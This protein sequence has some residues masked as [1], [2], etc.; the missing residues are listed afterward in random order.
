MKNIITIIL[1]LTFTSAWSQNVRVI[2]EIVAVIGEN[3]VMRSELEAEYAQA[4]KDMS[5][6]E[7]DLKC[8]ILNQLVIQKLYLH[9]GDVDSVYATEDRV[10]AEVDR[11]IKYYA[12]Q[13]GG[14]ARLEEYLGKSVSEYKDQMRPKIGQ[15]MVTQQVKQSLISSV[16]ASPTDVRKF[17]ND[18]PKDSLPEFGIEVE[19]ALIAMKPTSSDYAKEYALEKITKIRKDISSGIY[20]FDFAAKSSSDDK[21]TSI[22]GGDLGYFSRGQ[23]VGAFERAAFKLEKDS[24]SEVIETEYGYHIIQLLDRKGDKVNARHILIK[25]LIVNSDLVRLKGELTVLQEALKKDSLTMCQVAGKYSTDAF[26]KDNCG[27]YADQTTGSQQ[28]PVAALEPL[29]AAKVEVLKVGEYSWPEQFE[30]VDGTI[31]YRFFYLR[32]IVPAHTA[33]L[34]DDYQKVQSLALE[35]K[36]EDSVKEWTD[37][38]KKG[39]Y[40]WIDP[41]FINCTELDGWKGLSN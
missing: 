21:G 9:K 19:L 38:Y 20:S 27:F 23:M 13:I 28:V 5:Y 10:E 41:L 18:I 14:E 7:G 1:L 25:P 33:N 6:Y 34:K 8:E 26:T 12:T 30:D 37:T 40:V 35:K 3:I 2:D 32:K 15:Q 4:K 39:V 24:I 31:G 16:K 29:I 11:R 17:F 22:N 36:Q